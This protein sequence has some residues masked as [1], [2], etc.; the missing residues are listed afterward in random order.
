MPCGPPRQRLPDLATF[1]IDV[2]GCLV[3]GMLL[4][5]TAVGAAPVKLV[6]LF[7]TG[8]AGAFTNYSTFAHETVAS[9]VDLAR[10]VAVVNVL[11]S[12]T[13]G[14]GGAIAGWYYGVALWS[15]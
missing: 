13:V 8:F 7:G 12:V 14:L 10:L 4:P 6:A 15:G 9:S 5:A 1:A 2:L 3:L 11:V